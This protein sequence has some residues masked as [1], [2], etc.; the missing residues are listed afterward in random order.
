MNNTTD[1]RKVDIPELIQLEIFKFA[2]PKK[3]TTED[4]F[5]FVNDTLEKKF[6]FV[7][8]EYIKELKSVIPTARSEGSVEMPYD[9]PLNYIEGEGF[10]VIGSDLDEYNLVAELMEIFEREVG[11]INLELFDEMDLPNYL[12]D[13]R[14]LKKMEYEIGSVDLN[15]AN[16]N[17]KD[18]YCVSLADTLLYPY[19][20]EK[21]I[22][23]IQDEVVC[24]YLQ[25]CFTETFTE[26]VFMPCPCCESIIYRN[27][28]SICED[29]IE[30]IK[31]GVEC[32]ENENLSFDLQT[33]PL[34]EYQIKY[35]SENYE[36]TENHKKILRMNNSCSVRLHFES[37]KKKMVMEQFDF[38]SKIFK[39]K[40]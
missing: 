31:V 26:Q 22:T 13:I 32:E 16:A 6:K 25:D 23:F 19:V 7:M 12:Y 28:V 8:K 2:K 35:W 34:S 9:E 11:I 40:V 17:S 33:E 20:R 10:F 15:R 38:E 39:D 21:F 24:K 36:D 14:V 29:C 30:L 27:K 18:L 1:K 37:N 5:D 3:L 4:K